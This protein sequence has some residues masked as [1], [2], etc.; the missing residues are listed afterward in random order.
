MK[1][2]DKSNFKKTKI[3]TYEWV[4]DKKNECFAEIEAQLLMQMTTTT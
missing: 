3:P 2:T 4:R 1:N